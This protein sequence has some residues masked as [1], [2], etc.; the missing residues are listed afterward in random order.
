MKLKGLTTSYESSVRKGLRVAQTVA[1]Q[2]EKP[3]CLQGINSALGLAVVTP[4]VIHFCPFGHKW[5]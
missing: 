3:H 2:T 4:W 1:Q 5:T